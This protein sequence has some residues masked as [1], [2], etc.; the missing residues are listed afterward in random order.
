[1]NGAVPSSALAQAGVS[2]PAVAPAKPPKI[3]VDDVDAR[4]ARLT[5]RGRG[6]SEVCGALYRR[7]GGSLRQRIFF[8]SERF[9]EGLRPRASRRT[10]DSQV[11]SKSGA[12]AWLNAPSKHRIIFRETPRAAGQ[13]STAFRYGTG[14]PPTRIFSRNSENF[15][16]GGAS[17]FFAAKF[18]GGGAR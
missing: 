6:R 5:D 16:R 4:S 9:S 3:R 15:F 11:L 12:I 18:G 10:R 13:I 14:G 1:M 2:S 17:R 8:S 7:T